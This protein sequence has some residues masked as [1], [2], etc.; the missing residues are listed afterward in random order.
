VRQRIPALLLGGHLLFALIPT[1]AHATPAPES[2][3][4]LHHD[5][6]GHNCGDHHDDH[7]RCMYHCEERYGHGSGDDRY[8]GRQYHDG[9]CYHHDWWGWHRC[10]RRYRW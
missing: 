3:Q 10:D 2:A 8:R 1:A 4:A 7:Y 6:Y 5:C 9:E